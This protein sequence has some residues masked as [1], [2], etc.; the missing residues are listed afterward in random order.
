MEQGELNDSPITNEI[1]PIYI[2]R[3]PLKP[4]SLTYNYIQ[5]VIIKKLNENY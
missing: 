1:L 3:T 2:V 4:P 5:L